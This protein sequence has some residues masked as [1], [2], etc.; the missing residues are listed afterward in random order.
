MA[1]IHLQLHSTCQS[2]QKKSIHATEIVY[3]RLT[4][5]GWPASVSVSFIKCR[6]SIER[7]WAQR[8]HL[9]HCLLFIYTHTHTHTCSK[10]RCND[11]KWNKNRKFTWNYVY[12]Q[13]MYTDR[14]LTQSVERAIVADLFFLLLQIFRL[15]FQVLPLLQMLLPSSMLL[16]M[17]LPLLLLPYVLLRFFLSLHICMSFVK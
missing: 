5:F 3:I 8:A 15:L 10:T 16:L 11:W 13:Y 12:I 1:C 7:D 6:M 2:L 17:R 14:P 4:Y 9:M